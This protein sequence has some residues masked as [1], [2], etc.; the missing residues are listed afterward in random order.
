[1]YKYPIIGLSLICAALGLWSWYNPR[2][3]P[4]PGIPVILPG[5]TIYLLKDCKPVKPGKPDKPGEPTKPRE[6]KKEETNPK[7]KL[8]VANYQIPKAPYGGETKLYLEQE[9]GVLTQEFTH[10]RRPLLEVEDA[11]EL[12]LRWNGEKFEGYGRWTA[13]RV[14]S[15]H[16]AL[17]MDTAPYAGVEVSYR[18]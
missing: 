12:G 8:N 7:G 18:W 5:E 15:F 4:V 6:P 2:E 1:M 11:K 13:L 17:Y 9:T 3:I 16:A 10:H 14:G